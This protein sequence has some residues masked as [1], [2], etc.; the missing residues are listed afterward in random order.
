MAP[1][2]DIKGGMD[3]MIV[4][5]MPVKKAAWSLTRYAAVCSALL[6]RLMFAATKKK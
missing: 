1:L 2:F 5:N 3:F 4:R 6:G